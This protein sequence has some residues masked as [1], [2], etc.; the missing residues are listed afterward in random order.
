MS[1]VA[2]QIGVVCVCWP[3]ISLVG[4]SSEFGDMLL[5]LIGVT[6]GALVVLVIVALV[7]KVSVGVTVNILV[8]I[9][10]LVMQTVFAIAPKFTVLVTVNTGPTV[11]VVL[12]MLVV[13]VE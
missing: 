1:V 10:V 4:F 5:Q 8:V 12:A 3:V 6:E 7:T 9:A 13:A 2:G 11:T